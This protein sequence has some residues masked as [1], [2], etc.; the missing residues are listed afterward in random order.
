[1]VW[2]VEQPGHL[3]YPMGANPGCTVVVAGKTAKGAFD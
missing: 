1:V 3:A 2:D